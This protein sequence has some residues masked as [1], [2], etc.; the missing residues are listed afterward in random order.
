MTKKK[1][2]QAYSEEFR[3]EAVRRADLPGNTNASVGEELG[4]SAQQIYNWRRQFNRL[5]DKQLS[6]LGDVQFK[7]ADSDEVKALKRQLADL[8]EENDFLKNDWQDLMARRPEL[9][10]GLVE[11][12]RTSNERSI[13]ELYGKLDAV[14]KLVG[15]D[16]PELVEP[17]EKTLSQAALVIYE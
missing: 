7:K 15:E 13:N 10:K 3:K 17:I 12:Q 2:T 6:K 11:V 8:K 16:A 14:I 4:I 1:K 9:A 5:T